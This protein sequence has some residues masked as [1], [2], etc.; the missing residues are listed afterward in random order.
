MLSDPADGGVQRVRAGLVLIAAS[1]ASGCGM[2][3]GQVFIAHA[4]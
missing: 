3:E 1:V 2:G 4:R